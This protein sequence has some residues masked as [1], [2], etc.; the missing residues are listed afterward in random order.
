MPFVLGMTTAPLK[1]TAPEPALIVMM[2]FEV[3][4]LPKVSVPPLVKR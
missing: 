4:A 1:E 3:V 2:V